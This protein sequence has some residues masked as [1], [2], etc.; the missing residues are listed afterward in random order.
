MLL[1]GGSILLSDT[2][3]N[4]CESTIDQQFPD[5]S[6]SCCGVQWHCL[7]R[8]SA[9]LLI[10]YFCVIKPSKARRRLFPFFFCLY[11]H[12][13]NCNSFWLAMLTLWE[14][15]SWVTVLYNKKK[16]CFT[17]PT[18]SEVRFNEGRINV[19][20]IPIQ[21]YTVKGVLQNHGL[22]IKSG[23]CANRQS[24]VRSRTVL[25][26]SPSERQM[27]S[28]LKLVHDVLFF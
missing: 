22:L 2:D 24:D 5:C 15:C 13:I 12:V 26:K 20:I 28:L 11:L 10:K 21:I 8:L 23:S 1:K 16:Q 7:L 14:I 3:L 18:I 9:G 19:Q 6:T 27:G 25:S 17:E 4:V